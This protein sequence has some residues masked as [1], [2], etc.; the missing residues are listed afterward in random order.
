VAGEAIGY[1]YTQDFSP[2]S[3]LR[4]ARTAASIAR[5]GGALAPAALQPQETPWYYQVERPATA[6][7]AAA[8]VALLRRA[9]E[10]ARAYAPTVTHVVLFF[11]E[12]LRRVLVAASEGLLA[13]DTQPRCALGATVVSQRHGDRQS[14]YYGRAGRVG[15]EYFEA[16]L[17]PEAIARE[18]AR[19]AVLQHEAVE[20]PAGSMPVVLGPGEAGVLIHEAVGHGLEADFNRKGTSLYSGRLGQQVA[21]PGVTV[22]DDATLPGLHGT[23]NIDDEGTPGQRTVLIENG[24]LAGY[25]HDWI[26]A[27]H[28]GVSRTGNGRRQ[29]FQHYPV[30]RMTNTF[31]APG[32]Y[33]P[34]EIVRAV[35]R[36]VY[37]CGFSGGQVNIGNGDFVFGTTEAYLIEGGRRT[38]PLKH[39][40]V[41]GNGPDLLRKVTMVGNDVQLTHGT[42][43]CGKEGQGV[44]VGHGL[45]TVLVSELTV[46]GSR[47]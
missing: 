39:V 43:T 29:S 46:G 17:P 18:A 4:A 37:C 45:P 35:E 1:A 20:A 40:S 22:I 11:Q 47:R 27:R 13:A 15:I 32:P 6:A 34:E 33:D 28:F 23:I 25:L 41:I 3:L 16:A 44:P 36:G 26:S 7:P 14:A 12:E 19:M 24:M 42:W 9:D 5:N 38:A 31:L 30:P 8:K 2:A 21:A 10:A